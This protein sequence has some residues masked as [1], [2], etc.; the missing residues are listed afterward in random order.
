MFHIA[1]AFAELERE[2]IRERVKAG[3]AN[4]KRRGRKVGRPR[5]IVNVGKVRE[6]AANGLSARAIAKTIGVSDTRCAGFSAAARK[7]PLPTPL[8]TVMIPRSP[9]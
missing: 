1:G 8:Q 3:L 9:L 2:I 6:M 4:A 7:P 5:A